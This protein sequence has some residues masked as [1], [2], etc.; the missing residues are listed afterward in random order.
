MRNDKTMHPHNHNK[1]ISLA[2]LSPE[3]ATAALLRV[4]PPEKADKKPSGKK[5]KGET[6]GAD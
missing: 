5:T 4:K 2:P 6:K 1:P 3:E